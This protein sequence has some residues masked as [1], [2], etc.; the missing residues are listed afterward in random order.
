M[1]DDEKFMRVAIEEAMSARK[2][3]DYAIGA[4]IVKDGQIIARARNRSKSDNDATKHA[5]MVAIQEASKKLKSRYLNGCILYTTHEPCPMCAAA[6]VWA[7][8]SRIVSGARMGDMAGYSFK[9]GNDDWKW[10]TISISAREVLEK[11]EPKV[12]LTEE[13]MRSECRKLFYDA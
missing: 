2:N 5:E 8:M 12:Q 3:G 4:V 9:N 11:G 7:K 6:T 13:C 10:R 1:S